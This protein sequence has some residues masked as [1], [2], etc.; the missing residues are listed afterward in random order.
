MLGDK[1]GVPPEWGLFAVIGNHGRGQAFGDEVPGV[2][3]DRGQA[4]GPQIN[5]VLAL[6]VEFAA[7][8][9]L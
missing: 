7:E 2:I 6:E 3:D 1:N 4:F 9:R 8:G 5:E